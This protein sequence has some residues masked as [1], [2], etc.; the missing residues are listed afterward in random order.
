MKKGLRPI[1]ADVTDWSLGWNS[2]P[3]EEGIK[4]FVPCQTQQVALG[5]NS[6]P[7]E[8]GIKTLSP[9]CLTGLRGWNSRPDEEGIKTIS[10]LWL[11]CGQVLEQQT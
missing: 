7:D 11:I 5:W 9:V 8:E 3:D 4:T 2:R 10:P 6:R 1:S